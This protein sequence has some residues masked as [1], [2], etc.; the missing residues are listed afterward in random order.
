[1]QQC[2]TILM[3]SRQRRLLTMTVATSLKIK[4]ITSFA[5]SLVFLYIQYISSSRSSISTWNVFFLEPSLDMFSK[6]TKDSWSVDHISDSLES[7]LECVTVTDFYRTC[8]CLLMRGGGNWTLSHWAPQYNITMGLCGFPRWRIS[9]FIYSLLLQH[10]PP[11][12]LWS[13][14]NT[15]RR[16]Y[17][18]FA[19]MSRQFIIELGL[20]WCGS[21]TDL[22][23]WVREPD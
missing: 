11:L 15:H 7:R 23:G 4:P 19:S 6:K 18:Y 13:P 5:A 2:Y 12:C 3:I 17:W 20:P 22:K 1:M 10:H 16:K 8:R 9:Y 14:K 21:P